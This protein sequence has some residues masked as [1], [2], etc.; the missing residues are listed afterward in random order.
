MSRIYLRRFVAIAAACLLAIVFAQVG[1]E[2]H[3]GGAV[4]GGF[5]PTFGRGFYG[6]HFHSFY[7][8]GFQHGYHHYFRHDH[9][10]R[11][12]ALHNFRHWDEYGRGAYF[13]GWRPGHWHDASGFGGGGHW[14]DEGV[15][16]R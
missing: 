15:W 1:A 11:Y 8:R 9:F 14:H 2:A 6:G 4:H 12:F 7:W 13:G 10:E 5:G 16:H 3:S